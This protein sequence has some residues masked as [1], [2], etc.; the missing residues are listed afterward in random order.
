M[1]SFRFIQCFFDKTITR[2]AVMDLFSGTNAVRFHLGTTAS[3]H[4]SNLLEIAI[5]GEFLFCCEVPE[6]MKKAASGM[7]VNATFELIVFGFDRY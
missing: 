5:P 6:V 2:L 7:G 3:G 1:L 4:F